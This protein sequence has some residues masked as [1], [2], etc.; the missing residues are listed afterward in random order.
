MERSKCTVLPRIHVHALIYEIAHFS[1]RPS[2]F[3]YKCMHRVTRGQVHA[4]LSEKGAPL[5][6]LDFWGIFAQLQAILGPKMSFSFFGPKIAQNC[7]KLPENQ[8]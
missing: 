6:V 1:S 7:A 4:P 8:K 3:V 5:S 2:G